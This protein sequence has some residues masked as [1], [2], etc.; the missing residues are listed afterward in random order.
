MYGLPLFP[1]KTQTSGPEYLGRPLGQYDARLMIKSWV[2]MG[3][4]K[5][6]GGH[7]VNSDK[8]KAVD[9]LKREGFCRKEHVH[10]YAVELV[11]GL[12]LQDAEKNFISK[13]T[14]PLNTLAS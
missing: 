3:W 9:I 6:H 5:R 10:V 12:G 11:C 1:W 7:N 8:V 4:V 2:R 13:Q 14:T